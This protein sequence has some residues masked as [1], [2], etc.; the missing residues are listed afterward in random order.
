MNYWGYLIGYGYLAM[1]IGIA[2]LLSRLTRISREVLR[3]VLHCLIGLEW[4]V[5]YYCFADTWQ[6]VVIPA[7]FVLVN[8]LSYRFKIFKS[9]ERDS[10]NHLGTI[11]YAIAMTAMSVAVACD[12]RFMLPFG[13]AVFCLSF[14]D[15]AAALMGQY[16]KPKIAVF[17][18]T[19]WGVTGCFLFSLLAQLALFPLLG[20]PYHL[21]YIVA[22]SVVTALTEV[23]SNKGTDNLFVCLWCFLWSFALY[24]APETIQI[25]LMC[26]V[27]FVLGG[28][29]VNTR[30]FSL[31]ASIEAG[32][33]LALCGILGGWFAFVFVIA[34]YGVIYLAEHLIKRSRFKETRKV[35]Q[36]IQNGLWAFGL[37]LAYYFT[38]RDFLLIA[39]A[40]S[41]TQGLTDS[42]A[43]VLG[44]AYAVKVYDIVRHTPVEKGLSGGVSLVGTLGALAVS[45]LGALPCGFVFG[46]HYYLIPVALLPFLGMLLDSIFGA[47]VQYKQRCTVCGAVCECTAHCSRPTVRHS[48][49]KIFTNGNVNLLTNLLT[50][51]AAVLILYFAYLG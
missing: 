42:F 22:L 32:C 30:S 10:G 2:E 12:S 11:F 15:A 26:Y 44:N 29:T 5:L 50:T 17:R 37:I 47:T 6:I 25:V 36:I 51:A 33:M 43:G 1:L 28:V 40:V 49:A 27:G 41:I 45:M 35:L 9:I 31:P 23:V 16:L 4:L 21:E 13:I 24:L 48:G 7:S 39:Y 3:K 18:K 19:L 8:A 20:L 34:A 14:G 38:R 46:W